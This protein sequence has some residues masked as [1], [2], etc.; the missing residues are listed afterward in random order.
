MANNVE[1]VIVLDTAITKNFI[2]QL[3]LCAARMTPLSRLMRFHLV[4]IPR[5][6]FFLLSFFLL[7][8]MGEKLFA[9]SLF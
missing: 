3:L 1:S 5:L 6:S 8:K 2:S 4:S 9:T 7:K